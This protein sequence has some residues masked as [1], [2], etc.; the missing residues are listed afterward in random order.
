M[1]AGIRRHEVRGTPLVLLLTHD[2]R[3]RPGSVRTL[4]RAAEGAPD[5]GILGPVL[6]SRERGQALSYGGIRDSAGRTG[7]LATRPEAAANGIAECDWVEGSAMLVRQR[8]FYDAGLFDERF[9]LYFEETELCLRATRAGWR[10]GVVLDASA[11]HSP[12]GGRRPLAYTYLLC[13][14]GLEHARLAAGSSGV[15]GQLHHELGQ[16]VGLARICASPRSSLE[17]RKLGAGKLFATL[18]GVGDFA[19]RRFGPPPRRLL[20]GGDI[21]NA[22]GMRRRSSPPLAARVERSGNAAS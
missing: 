9:F 22:T 7:Q 13:R 10:I 15:V 1:N 18:L 17:A 4:L 12:G 16:S 14:N 19:L 21:R 11:E 6:W 8:V 20:P 3:L 5:F 2:A